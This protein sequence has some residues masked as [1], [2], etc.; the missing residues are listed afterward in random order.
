MKSPPLSAEPPAPPIMPAVTAPKP[1]INIGSKKGNPNPSISLNKPASGNPVC[2]LVVIKPG[3]RDAIP[4]TSSGVTCI[5]IVSSP[6][7]ALASCC[8]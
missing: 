1:G 6:R 2:G 7:P 4:A 3:A 5:S 8:A